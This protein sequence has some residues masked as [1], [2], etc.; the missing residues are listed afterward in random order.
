LLA[1]LGAVSPLQIHGHP[2]ADGQEGENRH[3]GQPHNNLLQTASVSVL[4]WVTAAPLQ[5]F[6]GVGQLD[7]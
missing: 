3:A 2:A 1:L 5:P 6:E 4:F 7:Q